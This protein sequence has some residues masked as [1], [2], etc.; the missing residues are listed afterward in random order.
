MFNIPFAT[1]ADTVSC[2][3]ILD[4]IPEYRLSVAIA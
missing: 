4:W 3:C 1:F 2:R